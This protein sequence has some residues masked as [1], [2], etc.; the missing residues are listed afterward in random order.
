[1]YP[2][3]SSGHPSLDVG[4]GEGTGSR[5]AYTFGFWDP[6]VTSLDGA[7]GRGA[8]SLPGEDSETRFCAEPHTPSGALLGVHLE[9]C[10]RGDR[11]RLCL[12]GTR[13]PP[14]GDGAY[15]RPRSGVCAHLFP[16]RHRK[17]SQDRRAAGP[18]C[19]RAS[20]GELGPRAGLREGK[21]SGTCSL[22]ASSHHASH[23]HAHRCTRLCKYLCVHACPRSVYMCTH[24]REHILTRR[25]ACPHT[26]T[27]RHGSG[28]PSEFP[29]MRQR[30]RISLAATRASCR[31]QPQ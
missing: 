30:W 28:H 16:P 25:C 27:H 9:G 4:G 29:V 7:R 18:V 12:Q 11:N 22:P 5:G 26:S 15:N 10:C 6:T 21:F 13:W 23:T 24:T 20:R 8:L 2:Q 3:D 19:S 17:S 31:C 1:M 14:G